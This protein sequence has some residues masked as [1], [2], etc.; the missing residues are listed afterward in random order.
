[1]ASRLLTRDCSDA[2]RAINGVLRSPETPCPPGGC[3][4][5]PPNLANSAIVHLACRALHLRRDRAGIQRLAAAAVTLID[6]AASECSASKH[7]LAR[8]AVYYYL[9]VV[10]AEIQQRL[11]AIVIAHEQGRQFTARTELQMR[12]HTV[13]PGCCRLQRRATAVPI[14]RIVC[15]R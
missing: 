5:L 13:V 15:T 9:A 14:V 8:D 6:D 11:A 3:P 10:D 1:M 12:M 2:A 7:E 4:R